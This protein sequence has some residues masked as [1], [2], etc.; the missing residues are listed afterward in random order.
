MEGWTGKDCP[1]CDGR[2]TVRDDYG[3][4]VTCDACGGS[5]HEWGEIPDESDGWSPKAISLGLECPLTQKN[6]P[7]GKADGREGSG[8]SHQ[9]IVLPGTDF[10]G[11]C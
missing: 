8:D 11:V 6:R 9:T 5:G 10:F 3:H 1:N 4:E 2:G 7:R